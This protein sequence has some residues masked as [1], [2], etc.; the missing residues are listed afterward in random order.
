MQEHHQCV[1]AAAGG[2]FAPLLIRGF[3]IAPMVAVMVWGMVWGMVMAVLT[4][5]FVENRRTRLD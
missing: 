5:W 2:I 4:Q 3:G 1:A